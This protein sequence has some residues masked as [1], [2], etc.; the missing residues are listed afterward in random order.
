MNKAQDKA[1]RRRLMIKRAKQGGARG[2]EIRAQTN[3]ERKHAS[4][5]LK[6]M[7]EVR[8]AQ[9][10]FSPER[11]HANESINSVKRTLKEQ[12]K[13]VRESKATGR[14]RKAV[15]RRDSRK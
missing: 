14:T 13:A 15:K 3:A 1:A 4:E 9:G 11:R 8:N 10:L 6:S 5:F 7:R 12:N 2:K